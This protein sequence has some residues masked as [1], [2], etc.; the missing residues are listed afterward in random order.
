MLSLILNAVRANRQL[1]YVAG[2]T[3]VSGALLT[4][5]ASPSLASDAVA[6]KRWVAAVERKIDASLRYPS[7]LLTRGGKGTVLVEAVVNPDGSI[8][9]VDM[10]KSSGT[11]AFD[12]EA[13]RV[14][15]RLADLPPLPGRT[16]PES[17]IMAVSFGVATSAHDEQQ[18]RVQFAKAT[19]QAAKRAIAALR[20]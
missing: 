16:Q 15:S 20:P 17:V 9:S 6:E 13:L 8:A 2:A 12:R 10:A 1:A 4:A 7:T 18:L 14:A 11:R 19:D 5:A 3:L